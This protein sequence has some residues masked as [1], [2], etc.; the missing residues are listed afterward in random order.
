MKDIE[1]KLSDAK[2]YR[3]REMKSAEDQMKKAKKKSEDSGK[4]WRQHEQEYETLRLSIEDLKNG[5]TNANEQ[6]LK[7][8][9]EIVNL[10]AEFERFNQETG[11]IA[12][13]V[14]EL[15]RQIKEQKDKISHQNKE[16]KQKLTRKDRLLK[17]NQDLELEIKK[18]ENEINKVKNDAKAGYDRLHD[19]ESRYPWI[20]EDKEYFGAKNTRYDY[21]KEDPEAAGRKLKN[22]SEHKEKMSR[23][24]N[25]K[26]MMLLEREEEMFREMIKRKDRVE[27]DKAK[28]LKTIA[29]LDVRK[30]RELH[31]AVQ[32]VDTNFGGI[33]SSIL[34]G[35]QAKLVPPAGKD[36]LQGL[37]FKIGFN[38]LWKESLSEL[39]GGQRSLV[40]L[41][42][43]L[44]MLKYKPAP[45]YILDE[46]DAALD[47]SH[48][49]NIGNMLR[50]HF[51]NSQFIVVSLK[52]GMFNNANVLFRTRFIDGMTAVSR[53]VNPN[54]RR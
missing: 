47:L 24:I 8:Q 52:D 19:L 30:K 6:I 21:S 50:N 40:A 38:G 17:Q 41:S 15:K 3:E 37:E 2:G 14:N 54:L 32:E 27:S 45:L 44:A 1:A 23:N 29:D 33:F 26:A 53:T 49:Q 51:T 12:D 35:T 48:T 18:Q 43:I 42:L 34:P 22:L 28:I 31:K 9:E 10:Q 11:D 16:I 20:P 13:Q 7:L 4:K 36:F 5:I 25:E 39:S 46:V